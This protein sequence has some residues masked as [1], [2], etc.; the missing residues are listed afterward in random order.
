MMFLKL[1]IIL[2]VKEDTS[3][4]NNLELI[5]SLVSP[6]EEKGIDGYHG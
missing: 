6:T 3:E 1:V 5:S 4:E 2:N